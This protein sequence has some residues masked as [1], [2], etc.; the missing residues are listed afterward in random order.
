MF[1]QWAPT[2][3]PVAPPPPSAGG[4]AA[5]WSATTVY[6]GGN[7]ASYNGHDWTAQ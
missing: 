1:A 6:T 2:T 5:A 7:I 4:C 3:L